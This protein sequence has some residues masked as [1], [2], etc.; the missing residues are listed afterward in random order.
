MAMDEAV[1]GS[2]DDS[3]DGVD[4][5]HVESKCFVPFGVSRERSDTAKRSTPNIAVVSKATEQTNRSLREIKK[6]RGPCVTSYWQQK[7][8]V[9]IPMVACA[10]RCH[11]SNVP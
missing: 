7:K 2:V 10:T 6:A 8:T 3:G 4:E 11:V 9:L 1:F 5:E